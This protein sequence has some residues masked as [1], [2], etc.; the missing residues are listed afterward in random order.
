MAV[1]TFVSLLSVRQR[2]L[3]HFHSFQLLFS[4]AHSELLPQF[5]LPVPKFFE[6]YHGVAIH[7]HGRFTFKHSSC[8]T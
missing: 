8:F 3:W 5:L 7:A 6:C 4:L 2:L 1:L